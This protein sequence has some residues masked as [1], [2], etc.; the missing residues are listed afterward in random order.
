MSLR[1]CGIEVGKFCVD[2]LNLDLKM[3]DTTCSTLGDD[4]VDLPKKIK[5]GA[6]FG[7]E[8]FKV[9]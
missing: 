2:P 6:L 4:P 1:L 5:G 8:S 9:N 7:L 3:G